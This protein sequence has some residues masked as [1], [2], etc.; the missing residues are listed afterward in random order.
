LVEKLKSLVSSDENALVKPVGFDA[1]GRHAVQAGIRPIEGLD[2]IGEARGAE[3]QS[4]G[5]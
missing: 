4:R 1:R 2:I 3:Y 5:E